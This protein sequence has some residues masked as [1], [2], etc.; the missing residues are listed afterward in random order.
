[1]HL[2]PVWYLFEHEG[3]F[4]STVSSDR[5]VRNIVARPEASLLVDI[6]KL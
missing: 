4:V 2:T 6:R 1:M 5:K 3:L